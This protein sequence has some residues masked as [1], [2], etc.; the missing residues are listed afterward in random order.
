[1]VQPRVIIG[2]FVTGRNILDLE[3]LSDRWESRRNAADDLSCVVDLADPTMR[4]L[5]LRNAATPGKTFLAKMLDDHVMAFG[6]MQKP[7]YN[8]AR[9]QVTFTAE[10]IE[11]YLRRV[12]VLPP[13]AL[14]EPLIDPATGE[15]NPLTDTVMSGWDLGTI[16]KKVLQ[17]F[18]TWPGV[19]LP[20]VFEADRVGTHSDT[21]LGSSLTPITTLFENYAARQ[22]GPDWEFR[23]QLTSDRKGI[24]LLFRTGTEAQ[25]RLRSASVHLWDYSV[26]EPSVDDLVMESDSGQMTGL[27]WT[28]GGR[29]AGE[30]IVAFAQNTALTDAGYPL[31]MSV[32]SDHSNASDSTTLESYSNEAVRINDHPYESWPFR[33]RTDASPSPIEAGKGDLCDIVVKNDDWLPDDTYRRQI[34]AL[35]GNENPDWIEV[36]SMEVP[37]G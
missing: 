25:P 1:M 30:A 19:S 2:D 15:S 33:V 23:P 36:T 16:M 31:F 21:I 10:G 32:D 8:K 4:A 26:P 17:Q 14:T 24:E 6:L 11:E 37:L 7:R 20:I 29:Q 35:G 5:E 27:A 28:T 3:T 18:L 13:A 9:R 22:N 34:V 12:L